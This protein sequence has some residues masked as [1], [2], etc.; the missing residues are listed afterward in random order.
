LQ[1]ANV[2]LQR[3]NVSLQRANVSLQRANVSLQRANV[4]LKWIK[5]S[6]Q[7]TIVNYLSPEVVRKSIFPTTFLFSFKLFCIPSNLSLFL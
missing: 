4:S 5:V 3:A 1:R 2:S 6:L 7:R